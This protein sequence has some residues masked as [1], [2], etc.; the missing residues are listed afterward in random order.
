MDTFY[1]YKDS[2]DQQVKKESINQF[3]NLFIEHQQR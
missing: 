1:I 3:N 2:A